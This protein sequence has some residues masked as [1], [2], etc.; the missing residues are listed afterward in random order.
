MSWSYN[1]NHRYVKKF[2]VFKKR[3]KPSYNQDLYGHIDYNILTHLKFIRNQPAEDHIFH[4]P[5][6]STFLTMVWLSQQPQYRRVYYTWCCFLTRFNTIYYKPYIEYLI[7]YQGDNKLA[8]FTQ[9]AVLFK[10]LE[11]YYYTT[12]EFEIFKSDYFFYDKYDYPYLLPYNNYLF[13]NEF[14]IYSVLWTGVERL[15]QK[16][17]NEYVR[18]H[19]I[20]HQ[21]K[22]AAIRARYIVKNVLYPQHKL[23]DTSANYKSWQLRLWYKFFINAKKK[24]YQLVLHTLQDIS[25]SN[26]ASATY[27]LDN[28]SVFFYY[29]NS[30]H[31]L[32][33][34]IWNTVP[35]YQ[36]LNSRLFRGLIYV[37][38]VW[39]LN[40]AF[41]DYIYQ[42]P[43][44]SRLDIVHSSDYIIAHGL[45]EDVY[46]RLIEKQMVDIKQHAM[47]EFSGQ[48]NIKDYFIINNLVKCGLKNKNNKQFLLGLENQIFDSNTVNLIIT[49]DIFNQY[50]I[51][52]LF[53]SQIRFSPLKI[54]D[55][56]HFSDNLQ[57]FD[58]LKTYVLCGNYYK[59]PGYMARVMGVMSYFYWRSYNTD[60]VHQ[61]YK[62]RLGLYHY[63]N[64]LNIQILLSQQLY[65]VYKVILYIWDSCKIGVSS[66]GLNQVWSYMS[67]NYINWLHQYSYLAF[68]CLFKYSKFSETQN[69]YQQL[70][71]YKPYISF[72]SHIAIRRYLHNYLTIF[73]RF[74]RAPFDQ[75]RG[76]C[77]H[78][79][80]PDR[81]QQW[82][83]HVNWMRIIGLTR[84]QLP[85]Y[86]Y[87]DQEN[88]DYLQELIK[89]TAHHHVNVFTCDL[90]IIEPCLSQPNVVPLKSYI[91]ITNMLYE[92]TDTK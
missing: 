25:G 26:N 14:T 61:A 69:Y 44:Q 32:N 57:L 53:S 80:N 83:V 86:L 24:K 43:S 70:G 65:N 89:K 54:T 63:I 81:L 41:V 62:G 92:Y 66:L 22:Y 64:K 34:Y 4:K 18:A 35:D 39:S 12:P 42:F 19:Y 91:Q 3:Y 60:A 72:K 29:L 1:P 46:D 6:L 87:P 27:I 28:R 77:I 51:T 5:N 84:D 8:I 37:P 68:F 71:V 49:N 55:E 15:R 56:T 76:T 73:R 2:G 40:K 85:F 79:K 67:I 31:F 11:S 74:R 13:K 58:H 47:G 75:A 88:D 16:K 48:D 52:R 9:Q 33:N 50:L 38:I 90:F 36:K 7:S 59:L 20:L 21:A 78:G 30:K 23:L 82:L 45:S 10:S 17:Y